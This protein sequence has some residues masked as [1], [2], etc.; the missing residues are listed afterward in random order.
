MYWRAQSFCQF[1]LLTL[2]LFVIQ[3][4]SQLSSDA[5]RGDLSNFVPRPS[6]STAQCGIDAP[7]TNLP[8][9]E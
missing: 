2:T 7:A 1:W 4:V 5:K 6:K 8:V 3:L 9:S